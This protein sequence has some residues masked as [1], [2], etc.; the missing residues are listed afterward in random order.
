MCKIKTVRIRV[1]NRTKKCSKMS[2]LKSLKHV[3]NQM[4]KVEIRRN[5]RR[6]TIKRLNIII[7][8][9]KRGRDSPK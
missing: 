3:V 2:R 5:K 6:K 4:I 1:R 9:I 8:K 7:R